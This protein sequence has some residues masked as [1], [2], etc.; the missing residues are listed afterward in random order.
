MSPRQ[1]QTDDH[2]TPS[3]SVQRVMFGW[4]MS[5]YFCINVHQK[6]HGITLLLSE[7][8]ANT[9]GRRAHSDRYHR[10][11][12]DKNSYHTHTHTHMFLSRC[13]AV[14]N[15]TSQLVQPHNFLQPRNTTLLHEFCL[16]TTQILQYTPTQR[17]PTCLPHVSHADLYT[18]DGARI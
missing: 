8:S 16:A 2:E 17:L 4:Q 6:D 11:S 18:N 14:E 3:A 7:S 12:H 15:C 13:E 9:H 10:L 1:I 5:E